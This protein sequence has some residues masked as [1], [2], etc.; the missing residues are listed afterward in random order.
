MNLIKDILRQYWPN[1]LALLFLLCAAYRYWM[2]GE[3]FDNIRL[4]IFAF[5]GFVAVVASEE[6]SDWTGRYGFTRKQFFTTPEAYI[7]IGGGI[8][9]VYCTLALYRL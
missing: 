8:V 9:L 5:G 3:Y 1:V 7:R 6:F 4:M 2:L